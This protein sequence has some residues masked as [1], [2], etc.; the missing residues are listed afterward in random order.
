MDKILKMRQERAKLIKEARDI[1]DKAEAEK[2]DM[3]AEEN[4]NYEK[5]ISD[6]DKLREKIEKEERQLELEK[7]L[8]KS[9]NE[10]IKMDPQEGDNRDDKKGKE[11]RAT[12]FRK[13]L[14]SGIPS[15]DAEEKRALQAD[16]AEAGGYTVAPQEFVAQLI[17]AVDDMVF[18]R[19]FATKTTV[20]KAESLGI[21]SLDADPA[22]ADWTS[23]LAVGGE[24]STMDFGKRELHP[25]PLAKYIK[26]SNKLLR[27]S[28][29]NIDS[30]VQQR[31]AYKFAISEEKAFL[32]G[33]GSG[34]P[35]G[36]F[37][38]SNDG[39]P[40]NRDVSTGN[41]ATSIKFDGLIEAKYALKGQ[42]WAKAKWM[43]HR[44]ALKQISKLKDGE[45][46]YIWQS[47]VVAGQP[48]RILNIPVLMSEYVP[49]T[50]TTGL[51][52]GVIGDFSFYW[53]VDALDMT[54]Q[55][56]VELYAAANQTGFI[57]RLECDGAP[58]LSEAFCRIKLA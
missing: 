32:T 7:D 11:F 1:L 54:M 47:S 18:I 2:R 22:D 13:F 4:T 31:L 40:I 10:P 37:T 16:S 28:A 23:E 33:S 46:Q 36:I 51:Y 45:G 6:V 12:A 44:D 34:Q 15:L 30:L 42:Y 53:I 35:L 39:I 27:V 25:Y 58:V 49:N 20:T 9:V 52:V 14:T 55:R 17:K 19:Q 21:P 41:E 50:F 57:G 43:F 3:S 38:A 56:L 24:D 5:I 48:D 26:V 29:I 8:E